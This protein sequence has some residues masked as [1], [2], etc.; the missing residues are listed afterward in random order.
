MFKV[1]RGVYLL[2]NLFSLNVAVTQNAQ[3]Y[4]LLFHCIFCYPIVKNTILIKIRY[5][6]VPGF[7][8]CRV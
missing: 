8:L 5:V 6:F 2:F 7:L 1:I 4:F 3:M